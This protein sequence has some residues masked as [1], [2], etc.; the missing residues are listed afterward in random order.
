MKTYKSLQYR[1]IAAFFI[2]AAVVLVAVAAILYFITNDS[3]QNSFQQATDAY[4]KVLEAEVFM[5][6]V[7]D[8]N[9]DNL[10]S[11][12]EAVA[13]DNRGRPL[14]LIVTDADGYILAD[15]FNS[16]NIGQLHN[17]APY[18]ESKKDI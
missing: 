3:I 6:Y 12:L 16:K 10:Q 8:H 4:N 9:W 2:I 14:H 15:T 13:V 1:L 5:V 18:S 11:R 17:F 7:T